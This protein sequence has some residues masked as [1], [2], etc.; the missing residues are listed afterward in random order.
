MKRLICNNVISLGVL[1]ISVILVMTGCEASLNNQMESSS[2]N[3][4]ALGTELMAA[5]AAPEEIS[6]EET[7]ETSTGDQSET[8]TE[9]AS[10]SKTA[11]ASEDVTTDSSD[12]EDVDE[13]VTETGRYTFSKM[14]DVVMY[15]IS[16]LNVKDLPDV[17]GRSIDLLDRNEEVI[18]TGKCNETGWYRIKSNGGEAYVKEDFLREPSRKIVMKTDPAAEN[19]Q[20]QAQEQTQAQQQVSPQEPTDVQVTPRSDGTLEVTMRNVPDG[21]T[22]EDIERWFTNWYYSNPSA[23]LPLQQTMQAPVQTPEPYFDRATAEAVWAL[24]NAERASKGLAQLAWNEEIY[25]FAC[26]RAQALMSDFSHNGHGNYGENIFMSYGGDANSIH[27]WWYNSEGHH[28]NY[29]KDFYTSGACAI[30]RTSDGTVYAVEN[31]S[32]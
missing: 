17:V 4:T 8:E 3:E 13:L 6:R 27:T 5:S 10:N 21:W 28:Q 20:M 11:D 19:N 18:V 30:Y 9:I 2:V 31:F 12:E 25:Q 29:L 24:V 26:Q 32:P 14:P 16:P 15:T 1:G 22:N 23:Q 7:K